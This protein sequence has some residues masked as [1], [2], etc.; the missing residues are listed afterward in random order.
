MLNS[1]Q[2]T[3]T[4]RIS[5]GLEP[6]RNYNKVICTL[7]EE[8]IEFKTEEEFWAKVRK[9]YSEARSVCKDQ[10]KLLKEELHGPL[11]KEGY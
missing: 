11:S 4:R 5:I 10:F 6:V 1:E 2:T 7:H 9:L 8:L 3:K